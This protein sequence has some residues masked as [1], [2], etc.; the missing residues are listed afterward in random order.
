MALAC[1]TGERASRQG[2]IREQGQRQGQAG[3]ART[4]AGSGNQVATRS[5]A[6]HRSCLNSYN[7]PYYIQYR[8]S[9]KFI[10]PFILYPTQKQ[11]EEAAAPFTRKTRG[12][13][14]L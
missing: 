5:R 14:R 2:T 11:P 4:S 7:H 8:S 13:A 12:R 9:Q 10:Q 3:Q 6:R 1:P